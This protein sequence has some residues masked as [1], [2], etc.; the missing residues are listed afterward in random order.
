[1]GL[2]FIAEMKLSPNLTPHA[3]VVE[4]AFDTWRLELPAGPPGHYRLAQL[5]DYAGLPRSAFPWQPP[6]G[7]SLRGRA[8]AEVIPGTWG[9]GL[10]N[11]PF[12]MALLGGAGLRRLP[13]LPEAAW[14][15]FASPPNALSLR[16]D[17]PGQGRLAATFSSSHLPF[18][19]LALGALGLPLLAFGPSR[20]WL[21]RLGRRFV[22]Q[23]AIDL[24]LDPTGWHAYGLEWRAE[25]VRFFVDGSQVF[26][27][28]VSPRGRL[29]LV[30]WVDN[31]YA[32][33][34]ASGRVGWGTLPNPQ[35][36]WV[37]IADLTVTELS[38]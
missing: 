15:F 18:A 2:Y 24:A 3:R 1:M 10:W 30:L 21:R 26:E 37:E 12:G 7:L 4:I 11:D 20:R 23:D 22:R 32:A 14:F 35:P 38:F 27:T 29:G 33:L 19:A 8:S 25:C 36:V 31:Q 5:D 13:A 34:P 9:F 17:L 16:D 28:P 6:R